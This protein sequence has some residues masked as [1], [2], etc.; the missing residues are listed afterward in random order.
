M[1]MQILPVPR[2]AS[3]DNFRGLMPRLAA[4]IQTESSGRPDRERG[5]AR[6]ASRPVCFRGANESRSH[7][8]GDPQTRNA[9]GHNPAALEA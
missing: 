4:A 1:D 6:P 8:A 7:D 5:T 3:R 9:L 2:R